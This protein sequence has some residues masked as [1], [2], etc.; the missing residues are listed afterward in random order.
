MV[1]PNLIDLIVGL[2]DITTLTFYSKWRSTSSC[3][4]S[5]SPTLLFMSL[6]LFRLHTKDSATYYSTESLYG[7]EKKEKEGF[8]RVFY[9]PTVRIY[10]GIS[11]RPSVGS[12]MSTS[13]TSDLPFTEWFPVC[14]L[15]NRLVS[16][17][18]SELR[19]VNNGKDGV[20]VVYDKNDDCV[21]GWNKHKFKFLLVSK[22]SFDLV[23]FVIDLLKCTYLSLYFSHP[24]FINRDKTWLVLE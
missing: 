19:K 16:P 14:H 15:R 4:T 20:L 17:L 2:I 18:D 3:L 9:H 22:T 7:N 23:G 11:T 13:S 12:K 24:K 5:D 8:P 21:S 10:P 1:I 6:S